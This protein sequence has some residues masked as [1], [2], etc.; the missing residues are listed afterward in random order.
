M[1][2]YAVELALSLSRPAMVFL[3]FIAVTIMVLAAAVFHWIE[4][5]SLNPK[6]TG[7]F[8]SL[9]F[10]V[11]T[12]S[13]VGYGDVVPVTVAG[14]IVSMIMMVA[15]TAIFASFTAVIATSIIEIE[16]ARKKQ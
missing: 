7:F 8:D 15:G 3:I 4:G 16:A 12:M 14:K 10:T 11:T 2:D 5:A 13:G 9:Y 1:W 6:I